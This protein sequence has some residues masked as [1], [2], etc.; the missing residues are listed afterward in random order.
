MSALGE[1]VASDVPNMPPDEFVYQTKVK[2]ND[3]SYLEGGNIKTEIIEGSGMDIETQR[4]NPA[5]VIF[6]RFSTFLQISTTF[7][8]TI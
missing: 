4:P 1:E 5:A 6:D 7:Q 3:D 8:S 2:N